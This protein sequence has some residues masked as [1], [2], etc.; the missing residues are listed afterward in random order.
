ML[1]GKRVLITRPAHQSE[2][3]AD[4]LTNLGAKPVLFPTTKI[5]PDHDQQTH[6]RVAL[7]NLDQYNWLIF[8]SQN[9]VHFFWQEFKKTSLP[10][11][12]LNNLRVAAIG[13]ATSQALIDYD[14][15]VDAMP[16][17]FV[18]EEIVNVLGD[19]TGQHVLL[20]RAEGAREKLVN[21]LHQNQAIVTEIPLY[22]SITNS[23]EA[24]EWKNMQAGVEISTF[25]SASTVDG[26]FELLSDQAK[27]YLSQTIIV[28]IG[29]ITASTLEGY[30]ITSQVIADTYTIQ[31]LV[32]AMVAY[33]NGDFRKVS[34]EL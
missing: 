17:K 16:E 19:I 22:K 23:P 2:K 24:E 26:F 4:L 6:L 25:T 3:L 10:I 27:P 7:E 31:G 34:T 9:A 21:A 20:P 5:V 8:T 15:T 1:S 32:D 14:I 29:P 13:P 33:S 11:N 18:G 30:G 12:K 28:C